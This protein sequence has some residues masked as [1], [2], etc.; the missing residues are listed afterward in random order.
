MQLRI[1][2]PLPRIGD[3]FI[4]VVFLVLLADG[5]GA[6]DVLS[7]CYELSRERLAIVGNTIGRVV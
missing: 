7:R 5:F 1:Q 6:L 2:S 4:V 3:I